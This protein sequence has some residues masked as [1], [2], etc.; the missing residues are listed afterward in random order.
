[1]KPLFDSVFKNPETGKPWS[2]PPRPRQ[3]AAI[4]VM[5]RTLKERKGALA[6][7]PEQWTTDRGETHTRN[8]VESMIGYL[9]EIKRFTK[10][11]VKRQS[12]PATDF[13]RHHASFIARL[14]TAE[15]RELFVGELY[16]NRGWNVRRPPTRTRKGYGASRRHDAMQYK[17]P[18]DLFVSKKG[19][20]EEEA[21]WRIE[22]KGIGLRYD[23]ISRESWPF[24][25]M[26]V[27]E[28]G[29]FDRAVV[30]GKKPKVY[31]YL[32]AKGRCAALLSV[33]TYEHWR[34][35]DA[36]GVDRARPGLREVRYRT[37]ISHAEFWIID[38]KKMTMRKED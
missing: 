22:V 29:S 36:V 18:G 9:F 31:W 33:D 30:R 1:M 13:E 10:G 11:K 7:V 19:V 12:A 5:L 32:A 4:I 27:C 3:Y 26:I 14:D 24:I 6:M 25:D 23:F 17:D 20:T 8:E 21:E 15:Q 38:P 28:K 2:H 35:E 37:S 34:V 16:K